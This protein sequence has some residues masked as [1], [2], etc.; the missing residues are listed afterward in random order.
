M[1]V[2]KVGAPKWL[3]IIVTIW[4]MTAA[5]TAAVQDQA[6]LY[7]VRLI[8][9]FAEAGS[10][11]AYWFYLTRFYPDKHIAI[12]F[13]ITDSA[14]MLAQVRDSHHLLGYRIC[15]FLWMHRVTMRVAVCTAHSI[16][17]SPLELQI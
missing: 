1:I 14:I 16:M 6:T 15:V 7:T 10:F 5:C 8:L 2:Q 17:H 9:G 13:S 4:G 11:P 12:P 3:A